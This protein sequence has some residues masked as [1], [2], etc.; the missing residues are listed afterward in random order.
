MEKIGE[1]AIVIG[2]SVGGLLAARVLAEAFGEVVVCE[3]D[4]LPTGDEGR[5]AVPQ[6]CH[7][8]A[9]IPRGLT[10]MD[11]LFPGFRDELVEDGA[12]TAVPAHDFNFF[13]R[14]RQAA[15]VAIGTTMIS[16]SRPFIEGHL[17]RRVQ[18]IENVTIRQRCEVGGLRADSRG[19]RIDGVDL[20]DVEGVDALPADLVVAATGRSARVPAWLE[21][22]GYGRPREEEL[23]VDLGY[24]SRSYR[25]A[26]GALVD[27]VNL[28]GTKPVTPRGIALF[29]QEDDTWLLTLVGYGEH[30]PP[31]DDAGFAAF[32]DAVAPP[33]VAAA[34]R[35]GESL[36]DIATYRF[37]SN[38]RRRYDR[39]RLPDDLLVLGDAV[40]SFNPLYGQGMTVAAME[41]AA[42]R[43]CLARGRRRLARRYFRAA[44]SVVDHAWQMAID[45]DLSQPV[46]EGERPLSWRVRNAYS[47]RVL[48][49][50]E[51]DGDVT[52]A[53]IRVV[54]MLERPTHL[55]RP[56]IVRRVLVG[57]RDAFA[58]PGHP[59]RTPVRRRKLRVGGIATPLREAGPAGSGE[60]VVFVH[61]V[62]GSGADF[63]PL[64]AAAGQVGRA[65]A[66]DAPG[67]GR[68]DKPEDFD[69]S[70]A[71][72]AAFI[73]RAL[74]ELGVERAH[75]VLHDFGGPW[76]L[77]W[78]IEN[79]E[80]LASVTLLC[81]GVPIGYR[82]HRT[83]RL[84][85]TRLAGELAMA[86]LTRAGIG[87]S[88]RRSGPRRLPGPLVDRM[89]EDL[90]K[91]TRRAIL[92]LYRS[93]D[94][95][96]GEAP[97]LVEALRPLDRPA[98]V[99]WGERD[100]YVPTTLAERQREAFPS[101]KVHVLEQS[102]HWPFVDSS[103]R[104]EDLLMEHLQVSAL[105]AATA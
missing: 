10:E 65:V 70:V 27:K 41:A 35:D 99:I 90:D 44:R 12:A 89:Y 57:R 4:E 104:V 22:L 54:T 55:L 36:D 38:L 102:G 76:G 17:R 71:G 62:P 33:H 40:C 84:W 24:S 11:E 42:L 103:E 91:Q 39:M 83:A 56:G 92:R 98:L 85:R 95:P 58:W 80:R 16:A 61:G 48:V 43:A 51:T 1:R 25:L 52:A 97:R 93:A 5:R 29:A 26:P 100:P 75:L 63:E 67:F 64:L 96:A 50:A 32:I 45:G 53:F 2:A 13:I 34:L 31:S 9:L 82:W 59:P 77:A 72:H 88:L 49:A 47:E 3:R 60:A 19:R 78:A 14:G 94:D 79:P 8:H 46:V 101:A 7:G 28:L 87:A 73:D 18:A 86:T 30:R 105:A 6:G 66:W 15:R 74:R 23:R 20:C 21:Q 68:A 81:T 69:H 37:A